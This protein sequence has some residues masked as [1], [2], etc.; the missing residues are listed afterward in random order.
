MQMRQSLS[1]AVHIFWLLMISSGASFANPITLTGPTMGTSWSVIIVDDLSDKVVLDLKKSIADELVH[2]N[3]LMSTY[4]PNSQ[5]SRFNQLQTTDPVAMH[6]DVLTVVDAAINI[7]ELTGGAYDVTLGPLIRLWGFGSNSNSN[8][9][10]IKLPESTQIADLLSRVGSSN[11]DR[12]KNTLRKRHAGL[13]VDLS[14]IAK[15][16]AVDRIGDLVA[17]TGA[18]HFTVEIGGELLTRGKNARA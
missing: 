15:G 11:I 1:T 2:I 8:S 6:H 4:D 14:S 17:A 5:L 12:E 18:K 13:E 16:F 7:N 3:S 9:N 10:E